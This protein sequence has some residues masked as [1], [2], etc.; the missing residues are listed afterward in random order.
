MEM[1]LVASQSHFPDE[2]QIGLRV[3]KG[4]LTL[5]TEIGP[6]CSYALRPI[7]RWIGHVKETKGNVNTMQSTAIFRVK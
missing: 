4:R 6:F 1:L 3:R 7:S 5:P 2:S